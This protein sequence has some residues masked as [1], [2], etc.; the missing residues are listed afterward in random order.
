MPVKGRRTQHSMSWFTSALRSRK[1][2]P[3]VAERCRAPSSH[4]RELRGPCGCRMGDAHDRFDSD[5]PE[6]L[7]KAHM[8][9]FDEHGMLYP[10]TLPQQ[11]VWIDQMLT[12]DL[13]CYN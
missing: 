8:E 13:P 6:Q 11:A 2:E 9:R 4:Q 7:D 1:R 12:P 3:L 5:F 10:L